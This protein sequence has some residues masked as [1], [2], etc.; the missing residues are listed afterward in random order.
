LTNPQ[1]TLTSTQLEL[2]FLSLSAHF[3]NNEFH[4]SLLALLISD[5]QSGLT[6]NPNVWNERK[7][8]LETVEAQVRFT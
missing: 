3:Q 4:K 6:R 2:T 5:S 7:E 1:A 8:M